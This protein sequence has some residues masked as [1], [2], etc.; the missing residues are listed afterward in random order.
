MSTKEQ[1]ARRYRFWTLGRIGT[2]EDSRLN[3]WCSLLSKMWNSLPGRWEEQCPVFQVPLQLL[4][5]LQRSSSHRGEMHY[6]RRKTSL[7]RGTFQGASLKQRQ[8][9]QEKYLISEW[10]NRRQ[11]SAS[12]FCPMSALWYCHLTRIRLQSHALWELWEGVLL[13]LWQ[14]T[15]SW[16][17]KNWS[18]E[19]DN[20]DEGGWYH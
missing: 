17:Y 13:W 16:S 1:V 19:A 3:G 18:R 9:W 14:C 8:H 4:H 12:L 15:R 10:N 11:G 6:S 20:E 7:L 2:S 5:P